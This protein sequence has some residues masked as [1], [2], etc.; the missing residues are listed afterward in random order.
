MSLVITQPFF[1]KALCKLRPL[2]GAA[3]PSVGILHLSLDA[4]KHA[5]KPDGLQRGCRQPGEGSA[6]YPLE[7]SGP[8]RLKLKFG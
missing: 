6:V 1:A 3:C 4:V 5:V 8:G 7:P 2:Y